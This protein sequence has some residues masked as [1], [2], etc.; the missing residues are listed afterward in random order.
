MPQAPTPP[1]APAEPS[2]PLPAV[3]CCVCVPRYQ[4][5]TVLSL[6]GDQV[7]IAFPENTTRTF[8]AEFVAPA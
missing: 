1:Q 5:G 8:M 3:G 7:T 2:S 4:I 6:A